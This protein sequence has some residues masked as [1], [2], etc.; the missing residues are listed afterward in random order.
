M[1]FVGRL[2][3]PLD[4]SFFRSYFIVVLGEVCS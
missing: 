3:A 1:D 2:K 4:F